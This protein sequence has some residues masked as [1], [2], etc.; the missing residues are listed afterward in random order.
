MRRGHVSD[1]SRRGARSRAWRHRQL[2]ATERQHIVFGTRLFAEMLDRRF[3]LT[4]RHFRERDST[5][6]LALACIHDRARAI[7][8]CMGNPARR[9]ATYQDIVDAPPH[10]V[11]EVLNGELHLHPGPAK[12]HAAAASAL[13]E[14][15]GP[16]FKRGRGG[17]GG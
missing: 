17:P 13:G 4:C 6:S 12:P 8:E 11:A 15:L 5:I 7:L 1:P 3:E 14:E 9:R 2:Y 16:P 10:M